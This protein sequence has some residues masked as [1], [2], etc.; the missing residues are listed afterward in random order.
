MNASLS[1]FLVEFTTDKSN[2]IAFEAD[3]LDMPTMIDSEPTITMTE[4]EFALRLDEARL[5]AAAEERGLVEASL[6]SR[7]EAERAEMTAAF[8][9]ARQGWADEQGLALTDN[10]NTAIATLEGELSSSLAQAL[11]PLF[12]EAVRD[13]MM[14]EMGAALSAILGD[15]SHPLVRIE[16]PDDL[17]T[18]FG[19]AYGNDVAIDYVVSDRTEL[20]IVTDSTRIVSRLAACLAAFQ[21]SEG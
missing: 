8:E 4:A 13:R 11:R 1:R 3:D 14:A 9:A 17:L 6:L 20:T 5:E 21:S 7:F 15:P 12:A 10:L 19:G 18:A 2:E 16:G